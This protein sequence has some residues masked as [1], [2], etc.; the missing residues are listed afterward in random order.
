M[1]RVNL[2]VDDL[3]LLALACCAKYFEIIAL[4]QQ[5]YPNTEE[6]AKLKRLELLD[7][8]FRKL[9]QKLKGGS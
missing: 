5:E 4:K 3:E 1:P 8:K 7:T 9:H 2:T 6:R